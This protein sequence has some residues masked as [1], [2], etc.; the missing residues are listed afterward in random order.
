MEYV[1]KSFLAKNMSLSNWDGEAHSNRPPRNVQPKHPSQWLGVWDDAKSTAGFCAIFSNSDSAT[2]Y[3]SIS[4]A[5]VFAACAALGASTHLKATQSE[6]NLAS[7]KSLSVWP[8]P[9]TTPAT[10]QPNRIRNVH[11][12]QMR[13]SA[14]FLIKDDRFLSL[15]HQLP[16]HVQR[17]WNPASREN[18]V[19][20]NGRRMP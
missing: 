9:G 12:L 15:V 5:T 6:P 4:S 10:N 18:S 20:P 13:R 3:R 8:I 11:S 7:S 19:K 2:S 17:L 14:P 16:R 1:V